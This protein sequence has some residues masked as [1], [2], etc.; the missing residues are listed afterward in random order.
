MGSS[1]PKTEKER[2]ISL[3]SSLMMMM[4]LIASF[5][6]LSVAWAVAMV[7]AG[8]LPSTTRQREAKQQRLELTWARSC[9]AL[10]DA[11]SSSS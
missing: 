5:W 11:L 10:G 6:A 9:C 1:K 3:L 2:A 8:T 7:A 4:I